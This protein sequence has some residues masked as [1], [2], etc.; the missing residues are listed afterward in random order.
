VLRSAIAC[1]SVAA[2][3][4]GTV[5]RA[6]SFVEKCQAPFAELV[7]DKVF[8][9]Y[10]VPVSKLKPA[11]PDVRSG[12]AHTYRTVIRDAARLGPDFAGHYTLIEIGCG[13][14]TSCVAIANAKT[15]QVYFPPNLGSATS[16]L[17]DTGKFNLRR[18]NYRINSKLFIVA[19]EPNEDQKRAGMSYYLWNSNKLKLVRFVPAAR[20]C[21]GATGR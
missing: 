8:A 12:V 2:L 3:A 13:A 11:P 17:R 15:G 9:R 1:A 16:L 4:V 18:L 10:E 7:G 5:A 20:L 14:A 6:Q 19:G 21:R